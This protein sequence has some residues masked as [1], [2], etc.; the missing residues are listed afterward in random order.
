[1]YARTD[2]PRVDPDT[3]VEKPG[4]A[5]EIFISMAPYLGLTASRW[6][7]ALGVTR[8]EGRFFSYRVA[9]LG[10]GCTSFLYIAT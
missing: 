7:P 9:K 3:I 5:T 6:Q 10:N 4:R 8:Q 1:M 2:H